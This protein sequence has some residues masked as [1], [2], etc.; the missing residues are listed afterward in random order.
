MLSVGGDLSNSWRCKFT[1]TGFLSR[2][3]HSTASMLTFVQVIE[4]D[5]IEQRI[6]WDGLLSQEAS[7]LRENRPS[8]S[9]SFMN[10][11]N[12]FPRL[13][14][15]IKTCAKKPLSFT[16][17]LTVVKFISSNSQTSQ[18]KISNHSKCWESFEQIFI[19]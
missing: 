10:H 16:R 14:F 9:R 13:E 2:K 7:H 19:L 6:G 4:W 11:H 12:S 15:L 18:I 17:W 8:T 3:M 5:C 1:F